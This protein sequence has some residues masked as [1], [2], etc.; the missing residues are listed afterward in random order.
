M[1]SHEKQYHPSHWF[2]PVTLKPVTGWKKSFCQVILL[3]LSLCSKLAPLLA[4]RKMGIMFHTNAFSHTSVWRGGT[5]NTYRSRCLN[6]WESCDSILILWCPTHGP[7]YGPINGQN[8]CEKKNDYSL[9]NTV[10]NMKI[11]LLSFYFILLYANKNN[12]ISVFSHLKQ[13]WQIYSALIFPIK[14]KIK[15]RWHTWI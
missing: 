14:T 12:W 13:Y 7:T 4:C 2:Y 15:R 5:W 1:F 3:K 10:K 8:G 11:V 9:Q 6:L